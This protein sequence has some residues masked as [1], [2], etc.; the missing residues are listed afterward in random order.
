MDAGPERQEGGG[1]LGSGHPR[2]SGCASFVVFEVS[3]L[4]LLGGGALAGWPGWVVIL[5]GFVGSMGLS[6]LVA[7]ATRTDGFEDEGGRGE[8]SRKDE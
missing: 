8:E 5:V 4:V 6:A 2:R 1:R 7:Y 3:A